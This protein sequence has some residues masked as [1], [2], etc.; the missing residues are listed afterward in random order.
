[1]DRCEIG[2]DNMSLGAKKEENPQTTQFYQKLK[3]DILD[4]LNAEGKKRELET[5]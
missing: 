2:I 1:M 3:T 5:M 4:L